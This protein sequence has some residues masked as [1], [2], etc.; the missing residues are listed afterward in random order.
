MSELTIFQFKQSN[1]IYENLEENYLRVKE[2]APFKRTDSPAI[3]NPILR[4]KQWIRKP[5]EFINLIEESAKLITVTITINQISKEYGMSILRMNKLLHK[6]GVQYNLKGNWILYA[7]YKGRGYT[8]SQGL[9]Y[10]KTAVIN[11]WTDEGKKFLYDFLKLK[12]IIPVAEDKNI[13]YSTDLIINKNKE[14]SYHPK[15]NADK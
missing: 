5:Q 6:Y 3:E 7:K 2:G 11:S 15:T 8:P 12:S 1:D 14:Q 10:K 4:T 13:F 9:S